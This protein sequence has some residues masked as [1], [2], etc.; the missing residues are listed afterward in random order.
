MP[1]TATA[2]RHK[3]G[4]IFFDDFVAGEVFR[5]AFVDPFISAADH[6]NSFELRKTARHFLSEK[7]SCGGK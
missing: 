2:Q 3:R 1:D 4:G 5:N 7:S 6:H